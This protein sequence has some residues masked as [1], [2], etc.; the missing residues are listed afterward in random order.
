MGAEPTSEEVAQGQFDDPAVDKPVMKLAAVKRRFTQTADELLSGNLA[1][2]N[3]G[4]EIGD[5]LG[6]GPLDIPLEHLAIGR[7]NGFVVLH[8]GA[9]GFDHKSLALVSSVGVALGQ[10]QALLI[11]FDIASAALIGGG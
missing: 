2:F 5:R 7:L 4:F 3:L 6:V 11:N 8:H 10:L 9:S 1:I